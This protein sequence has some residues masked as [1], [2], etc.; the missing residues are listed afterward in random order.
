MDSSIGATNST[1]S[2]APMASGGSTATGNV[3]IYANG[4]VSNSSAVHEVGASNTYDL[5]VN[6]DG[7]LIVQRNNTIVDG[8]G[9]M[10]TGGS[11][12][13]SRG[14]FV[15]FNTSGITLE[16]AVLGPTSYYGIMIGNV[17]SATVDNV[18][19]TNF[20]GDALMEF[21]YSGNITVSGG[22][23][24][25]SSAY[26]GIY[27]E[28]DSSVN[29]SHNALSGSLID[30]FIEA[31]TVSQFSA[32]NNTIMSASST[33]DGIYFYG[34]NAV[35]ANN[36]VNSTDKAIYVD[37][38]LAVKTMNN[39][40]S[41]ST[42]GFDIE[43]VTSYFSYGD[44]IQ[45]TSYP[46]YFVYDGNA[47][48]Q[49]GNF[50]NYTVYAYLEYNY[51]VSFIDSTFSSSDYGLYIEENGILNLSGDQFNM[52]GSSS[53]YAIYGYYSSGK[54][55]MSN[56]YI[57]APNGT[58]LLFEVGSPQLSITNSH[59]F[60]EYGV[61][62][63]YSDSVYSASNIL[64]EGN[65]FSGQ[66]QYAPVYIY[67]YNS[68]DISILNNTMNYSGS[69]SGTYGI[70]VYSYYGGANVTISG[71]SIRDFSNAIYLYD[72][73]VMGLNATIAG[74]HIIKSSDGIYV[75]F[76][77]NMF[78]ESNVVVNV[79]EYG[80]F[81][82]AYGPNTIVTGNIVENAAGYAPMTDA[83]YLY[84]LYGGNNIVAHN[85]V[86]NPGSS[87]YGIY[88]E[89]SYPA[90]VFSNTVYGG[91]TGLYL[92]DNSPMSVFDNTVANAS[93]G[94]YSSEN[95]IFSYYS[96]TVDNANYSFESIDDYNGAVFA[97]T[98]SDSQANSTSLYFLYLESNLA[99]ITFYHNN[100][101]N[102]TTNST[103]SDYIYSPEGPLFMNEALPIGG[104]YWSNYTGTGIN[105]IGNTPMN[106][107]GSVQDL[108]PLTYMWTSPTVTF[109]E[110]GLPSGTQWTVELGS[111]I[112]EGSN[113]S[114][115]FQQANGKYTTEQYS[116]TGAAGY[117]A[118]VSTGIVNMDGSSTVV[119]VD[120]TPVTYAVS[121]TESG[122][123]NGTSWSVTLN[124]VTEQTT[125]P[126]ITFE[127]ANGT[128]NYTVTAGGDY[129]ASTSSGAVTVDG[130]GHSL[131][132][133]FS[134]LHSLTID[135]KGLPGGTDW[136]VAIG[137][138]TYNSTGTSITVHLAKGNYTVTVMAP[139]GY[140]YVMSPD[141]VT[142][143]TSNQTLNVSFSSIG[144]SGISPVAAYA[145]IGTAAVIGGAVGVFSTMFS[146]GTGIFRKK[147]K[148]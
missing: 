132:V 98:F 100:F 102:S 110:S 62:L 42:Y 13:S 55:I 38:G 113:A 133:A 84:G 8:N 101:L 99:T 23:F 41:N 40:V 37:G 135:E 89:E 91:D 26:Y 7:S 87:A 31:G 122:L 138:K 103:T 4:T 79:S 93:C 128:Y 54:L 1:Y 46:V 68:N 56:D 33:P 64:I 125:T 25:F 146:T 88:L 86:I 94:I 83:F 39:R 21:Y 9:L 90:L 143:G 30:Y 78:I 76:F 134:R 52:G 43:Y 2:Y 60:A 141:N 34:G 140:S 14:A 19:S 136:S 53:V 35:I 120:F 112:H 126:G 80:I 61:Y 49:K 114:M 70:Y 32:W 75:Y 24:S 148:P 29:V 51:Q 59:F 74:N 48:V 65:S 72:Y 27:A 106:V 22:N 82:E 28:Y 81:D 119:T 17:A 11:S 95:S 130:T 127:M 116:I 115:V 109:V 105:G 144:G 58:A 121:F 16:N 104:N 147:G 117:I 45:V 97:N 85:S 47:T 124:G 18:T 118:T 77:T 3:Y 44:S 12:S 57:Y 71:N 96:N 129:M 69:G 123:P 92:T 5:L 108:Y 66:Y 73:E 137:G 63:S 145:G 142:I 50:S 20:S 111:L 107:T 139:L 36:I 131:S 67:V 6:I 15:S 10:L